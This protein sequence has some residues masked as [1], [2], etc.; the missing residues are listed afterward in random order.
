MIIIKPTLQTN[1]CDMNV[2]DLF[3]LIVNIVEDK[4]D[5]VLGGLE[6]DCENNPE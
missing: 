6:Q 1:H 5:K 3:I 2:T 4:R